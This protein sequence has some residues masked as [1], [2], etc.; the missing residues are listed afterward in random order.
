MNT[1]VCI[2]RTELTKG[3]GNRQT[4]NMTYCYCE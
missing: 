1:T 3:K 4:S 2:I